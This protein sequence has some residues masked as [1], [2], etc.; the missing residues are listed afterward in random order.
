MAGRLPF[1]RFVRFYDHEKIA[2]VFAD[3]ES[4]KTIKP[5]LRFA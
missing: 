1:D 3:T 2:E 4:G 5:I